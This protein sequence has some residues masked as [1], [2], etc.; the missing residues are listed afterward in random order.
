MGH[1]SIGQVTFEDSLSCGHPEVLSKC[2]S[3]IGEHENLQKEPE[4]FEVTCPCSKSVKIRSG[5]EL[6][7]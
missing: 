6:Q 1:F 7:F 2:I 3:G 4:G 5:L